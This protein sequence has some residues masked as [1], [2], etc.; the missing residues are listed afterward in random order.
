MLDTD[1]LPTSQNKKIAEINAFMR[2]KFQIMSS[3]IDNDSDDTSPI[4][5]NYYDIGEF[6]KGKFDSSKSFSIFHL[7]IH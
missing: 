5:C 3:D 2:V 1:F 6:Q 7:N 4:N